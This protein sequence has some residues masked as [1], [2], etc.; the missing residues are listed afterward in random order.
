MFYINYFQKRESLPFELI[1]QNE[2]NELEGLRTAM[3]HCFNS[4][5]MKTCMEKISEVPISR[6]NIQQSK[7]NIRTPM[8]LK[9]Y[10]RSSL[11][12][13]S[14]Y[15]DITERWIKVLGKQNVLVLFHEDFYYNPHTCLNQIADF[16]VIDDFPMQEDFKIPIVDELEI[17][18][19]PLNDKTF[20]TLVD[21][22]GPFNDRLFNMVDRHDTDWKYH[23][24]RVPNRK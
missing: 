16:L 17:R 7:Y 13:N 11:L 8:D 9:Q 15:D 21:F 23:R 10:F 12:F 5:S 1:A 22:L 6:H 19:D 3:R 14:L 24:S 4:C 18:W 20:D 2:F